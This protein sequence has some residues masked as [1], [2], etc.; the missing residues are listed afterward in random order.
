MSEDVKDVLKNVKNITLPCRGSERVKYFTREE[1]FR[2]SRRPCNI[3]L[4]II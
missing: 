4:F 2:L 3:V 1:K